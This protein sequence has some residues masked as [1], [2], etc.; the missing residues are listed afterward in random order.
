M[1]FVA[2]NLFYENINQPS[3]SSTRINCYLDIDL[4]NGVAD[5]QT[6]LNL[7]F[8][9]STPNRGNSVNEVFCIRVEVL[10]AIN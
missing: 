2:S 5:A 3:N 6:E 9:K 7:K 4:Q 8:I 1:F 10:Q